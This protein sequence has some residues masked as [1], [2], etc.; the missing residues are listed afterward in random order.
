MIEEEDPAAFAAAALSLAEMAEQQLAD[1]Q[2]CALDRIKHD[3]GAPV[4]ADSAKLE[5]AIRILRAEIARGGDRAVVFWGLRAGFL[6][7]QL[8]YR[9]IEPDA[10]TG[11]KV[12]AGGTKTRRAREQAGRLARHN[13]EMFERLADELRRD[14]PKWGLS[15]IRDGVVELVRKRHEGIPCSRR[16]LERL[17]IPAG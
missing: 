9:A 7:R 12:R 17:K 2:A 6:A 16:T 10:V 14:H 8:G 4:A 1:W 11:R 3:P 15:A 13:V 5:W